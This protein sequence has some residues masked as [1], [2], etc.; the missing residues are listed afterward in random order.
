MYLTYAIA[1]LTN[2][3]NKNRPNT[4]FSFQHVSPSVYPGRL[5]TVTQHRSNPAQLQ[6]SVKGSEDPSANLYFM[7]AQ[8]RV[9]ILVFVSFV[10]RPP[11]L[12]S[13][14]QRSSHN[15]VVVD[16]PKSITTA[17]TT[18]IIHQDGL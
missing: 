10:G 17:T 11:L 13:V 9:D 8:R 3:P 2:N 12:S 1:V 4:V 7:A 15:F 14:T 16:L 5:S 18:T 6:T